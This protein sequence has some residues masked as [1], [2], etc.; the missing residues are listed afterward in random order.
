MFK[1][2]QKSVLENRNRCE[3]PTPE[4]E[5]EMEAK[6]L[7]SGITMNSRTDLKVQTQNRNQE[8]EHRNDSNPKSNINNNII[9][10]IKPTYKSQYQNQTQTSISKIK[11]KFTRSAKPKSK[12]TQKM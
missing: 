4:I 6:Q 1:H 3:D 2:N 10:N 9:I 11:I 12:W 5:T 7:I 8:I